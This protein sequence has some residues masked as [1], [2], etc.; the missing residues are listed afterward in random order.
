MKIELVSAPGCTGAALARKNL[1]AALKQ[2]GYELSWNEVNLESVDLD[3]FYRQFG[4]PT[5]L[6]NGLDIAPDRGSSA[7][8]T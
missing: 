6:I 3:E 7:G 8:S 4:S 1:T 2:L 5:I